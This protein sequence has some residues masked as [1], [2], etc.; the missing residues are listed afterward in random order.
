MIAELLPVRT[1]DCLYVQRLTTA[2]VQGTLLRMHWQMLAENPAL[3][4]AFFRVGN[5]GLCKIS[6]K[7]A[8]FLGYA[9]DAEEF[10]AFLRFS[11]VLQLTTSALPP[12]PWQVVEKTRV[13]L[14]F[15]G[16]KL[17]SSFSREIPGFCKAVQPRDI[18]TLLESSDGPIP[19]AARDYFYADLCAR[20]NHGYAVLY[21]IET[22]ENL[23]ATAGIWALLEKNAYIANVET[24]PEYRQKGFASF[25]IAQLCLD[26]GKTRTLSLLCDEELLTFYAR[27][28]F[29]A[30]NQFSFVS[31]VGP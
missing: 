1:R 10:G 28:G 16:T 18:L 24:R 8:L 23:L 13:L 19:P 5:C 4:H 17:P 29:V 21:G 30:T 6:G 20:R 25:L 3:P 7:R 31:V 2:P 9:E 22:E 11:Q 14:R 15:P 27:L 12:E 26:F